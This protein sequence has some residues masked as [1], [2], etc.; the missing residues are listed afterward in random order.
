MADAYQIETS[1]DRYLLEDGTGVY[2]LEQQATVT[3]KLMMMGIGSI[4][5]QGVKRDFTPLRTLIK[6]LFCLTLL[7]PVNAFAAIAVLSSGASTGVDA[8][9]NV[10]GNINTV[11]ASLITCSASSFVVVPTLTDNQSNTWTELT[12]QTNPFNGDVTSIYYV[13]SPATSATHTVTLAA[14][15]G[16]P[17]VQCIAWTGTKLASPFDVQNGATTNTAS[18]LATGS[19][20]PSENNEI[21]VTGLTCTTCTAEMIDSGFTIQ[22]TSAWV[23]GK[24]L[25][26]AI[27]YIIQTTAGAVNPTWS[28]TTANRANDVVATF[29]SGAGAHQLLTLGAGN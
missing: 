7:L 6:A 29:K 26:G 15:A 1:T 11:G 16:Q 28:W 4:A 12:R 23:S 25:E 10:T 17:S 27:G 18:S 19:V 13:V 3:P 2:L 24:G 21:V 9:S 22:A 20:T 8:N 14:L 5:V